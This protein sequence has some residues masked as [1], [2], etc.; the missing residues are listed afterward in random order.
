MYDA[1]KKKQ[2]ARGNLPLY[3][4]LIPVVLVTATVIGLFAWAWKYKTDYSS[5]VADFS[6]STYHAYQQNSLLIEKDG[7]TYSILRENIYTVYAGI[8]AR[9]SGRVGKPPQEAPDAVLTYGNGASLSLWMMEPETGSGL[10]ISFINPEGERYS[11]DSDVLSLQVL[12][13]ED[14]EN[15]PKVKQL[16]VKE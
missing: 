3:L 5:F 13:L 10:F 15:I 16:P 7:K 8:T 12:P 11:Y 4:W 14:Y 9:G 2:T 1:V 6:S